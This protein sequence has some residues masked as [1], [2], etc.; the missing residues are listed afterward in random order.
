MKKIRSSLFRRTFRNRQGKKAFRWPGRSHHYLIQERSM[1]LGLVL[2]NNAYFS[3]LKKKPVVGPNWV[4][5]QINY[6]NT[7]QNWFQVQTTFMTVTF[8][9]SDD[10]DIDFM[11]EKS[12][13]LYRYFALSAF[14]SWP[15]IFSSFCKL[16]YMHTLTWCRAQSINFWLRATIW[17]T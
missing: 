14:Q 2:F 1:A 3:K 11:N 15:Y 9:E 16:S 4:S 8:E 13:L 7:H 6:T 5:N 12:T 10:Y 17:S